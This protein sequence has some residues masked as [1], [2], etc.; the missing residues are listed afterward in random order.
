MIARSSGFWVCRSIFDV[1]RA[2]STETMVINKVALTY[3]GADPRTQR[4]QHRPR[5]HPQHLEYRHPGLRVLPFDL[6]EQRALRDTQP[7]P[8][9]DHDQYT[10]SQERYAPTVKR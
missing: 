7:D 9:P 4:D 2:T 3:V 1:S 10:A 5:V 6:L 8:Q